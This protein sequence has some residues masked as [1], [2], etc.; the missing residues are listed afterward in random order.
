MTTD[1][2]QV[3]GSQISIVA[4]ATG[5][6]TDWKVDQG[7]QVQS[8]EQVGRIAIQAGY[9]Q[10]QVVIR[11]PAAGTV[12]VDNGVEGAFVTA[13]TQLAVAYDSEGV[14][15][16]ARVDE[17]EIDAVHPG[18][19]AKIDVDA[20]PDAAPDRPRGRGQDR[21]RGC[22]LAVPAVQYD[23]QLPEGHPGD[24]G[25]DHH[26]RP[27]GSCAR[28]RHERHGEDPPRMSTD[29]ADAVT[30][31]TVTAPPSRTEAEPRAFPSGPPAAPAAPQPT[32]MAHWVVPLAVL[33]VGMFMSVLDISIVN[34][35][36]ATMQRDFAATTEEIQWVATP[37]R[38]RS[39]W[40]CR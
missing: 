21:C 32:E 5:T 10:P 30:V 36:I 33:I 23:G 27:E 12:A 22:V 3:D 38:W 11:A 35:A 8:Y 34:V 28:P 14:F 7:T 15:V 37:T 39:A 13:G 4:P 2:A 6:L 31:T 18:E 29:T 1:N 24:S 25:Q 19:T 17:T 40:S 26:R 20:F 9:S 16:T